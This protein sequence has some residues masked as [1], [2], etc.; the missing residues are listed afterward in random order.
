MR[1][2]GLKM[3]Y[4]LKWLAV[5]IVLGALIVS[6]VIAIA[7]YSSDREE[8]VNDAAMVDLAERVAGYVAITRQLEPARRAEVL[9]SISSRMVD[10]RFGPALRPPGCQDYAMRQ[11]VDR[12]ITNAVSGDVRWESCLH[13]PSVPALS[14][15]IQALQGTAPQENLHIAFTL[16]DGITVHFTGIVRDDPP[17]LLD[18]AV[19]YILLAGSLTAGAAYWM[20]QRVT[21]SLSHFGQHATEIGRNLDREPLEESGPAEV[22]AAAIAFNR[23]HAQLKRLVDGRTEML[24]AIS[25]DLRTPISRLKLRTEFLPDTPDRAKLMGT[26]D[27]MEE[28][29][30]AVLAFIRGAAPQEPEKLV[31]LA[32]LI[33]SIC[34]DMADSGLAVAFV[35]GWQETPYLCRPAALRRAITNIIDNA[36]KYGGGAEVRLMADTERVVIEV[37]DRGP[38]LDEVQI[39]KVVLPFYRAET[40]RNRETGGH[41]LGLSIAASIV[42]AHGGELGI[43]NRPGGGLAVSLILPQ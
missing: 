9:T 33:D 14:H 16:P 25:H 42:N 1:L 40:S 27:E 20:I 29:V 34:S 21:G 19:L 31:E 5:L 28:M 36:I 30:N 11:E 23:M 24:A 4:S 22:H 32:S 8:T 18:S 12:I 3:R 37:S 43:R 38:G 13:R 41:G 6:H 35:D 39:G 15:V 2:T 10:V 7:V 26:L 17:F